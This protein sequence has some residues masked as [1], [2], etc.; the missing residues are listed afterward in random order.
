MLGVHNF[1]DNDRKLC[2]ESDITISGC[3]DAVDM[4]SQDH[5]N[6]GLISHH[7]A[8]GSEEPGGLQL[9]GAEGVMHN[10]S[11]FDSFGSSPTRC[12]PSTVQEDRDSGVDL[13]TT[14]EQSGVIASRSCDVNMSTPSCFELLDS[15]LDFA[16]SGEVESFLASGDVTIQHG[17]LV[18]ELE[19]LQDEKTVISYFFEDEPV[20]C[21][22]AP[23]RDCSE[24]FHSRSF[25][26]VVK[27]FDVNSASLVHRP[28]GSLCIGSHELSGYSLQ[29]NPC[30]FFDAC[31]NSDTVDPNATYVV[32]GVSS[33]F[34][35]VDS[36]YV[37]GYHSVNYQSILHGSPKIEMDQ[38]IR[39]KL[40]LGKVSVATERPACIHSLGAV[41]K[42]DGSLRPI[43]DCKRPIGVSINN[44]MDTTC[45]KFSYVSI[46][47]VSKSIKPGCYFYVLDIKSAYRS[48]NVS[49]YDR[50]FQGFEWNL[51]GSEEVFLDHCL[52]F[53]LKCA[54]YIF[55][56]LTEFIVRSMVRKGFLDVYGYL[57]DFLVVAETEIDC[58]RKMSALI[59]LLQGLGFVVAWR[60]VV[61]PS[62]VVTYL[63]IELDSV[64]ME[65]RLPQK[66]LIRLRNLVDEF[67]GRKH[68]SLKELQ[69]L[70]GHL[71]HASTVVKG[72]R[73]FSRRIINLA[74]FLREKTELISLPDWFF[75]DLDWWIAFCACFNGSAKII[76]DDRSSEIVLQTDSSLSG[77][78]ARCGPLWFLGVWHLPQPPDDF[79]MDH[80]EV[81]PMDYCK[82]M[83]INQL[84]LWPILVA[85][86][87][88]GPSWRDCKIR[89]FTDNT[90]WQVPRSS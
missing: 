15:I 20:F 18:P 55:T 40:D 44:Y 78:G 60:K 39:R 49:P 54:P 84:E 8:G 14:G 70:A 72:G 88:W 76:G 80:W 50:R 17:G 69:V 85:A 47:D 56:Q 73:T 6:G 24:V 59:D 68:C 63:G 35:I 51:N 29:L 41:K 90:Q 81:S 10:A 31:Y 21:Y 38:T 25:S 9:S 4:K 53:G 42:S 22:T 74:K 61:P 11:L 66:K 86:R 30:A 45:T 3:Y 28:C 67:R 58:K 79:P 23:I 16:G 13:L 33:G 27:V 71:S 26:N 65:L 87:K 36:S 7:L 2:S 48:V 77:F 82:E 37:G 43:T 57:D 83:H 89:V 75:A 32:Q 64:Q 46:D 34:Q 62:Q 52:V 5:I 1:I 19:V 12:Y